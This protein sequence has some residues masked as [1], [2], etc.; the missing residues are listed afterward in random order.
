[1][2]A[3]LEADVRSAVRRSG[4]VL[5]LD[6][7]GSYG[8][9]AQ[10]LHESRSSGE[11]PYD[12]LA[13]TGSHLELMLALD[14]RAAGLEKPP[15][16]VHLP[17][18]NEETIK[19]TPLYEL[20]AAGARYRK[21]LETLV[22]E[23]A[24]GR[25]PPEQ[26]AAFVAQGP[27]TL[28][29]A[30][31]WLEAVSGG[32]AT[33][34]QSQLDGMSVPALVDDLVAGGAIARQLVGSQPI[35]VVWDHMR[36]R[37]GLSRVWRE[38]G[39][40]TATDLGFAAASWALCVEYVHDL[41]RRD[42]VDEHLA[43]MKGLPGPV[44]EACCALAAHLR[45]RNPRFYERTAD[46]TETW[47]AK[48]VAA[49]DARDLGRID[50]FR[51]EED[52]VLAAAL[53]ALTET[54]SWSELEL[55]CRPRLQGES[56]WLRTDAARR[57]AWLLISDAAR[58]GAA[59]SRA[60]TLP[61]ATMEEAVEHYVTAGAAVD[62]THRQLEQ[63]RTALLY[64]QLPEYAR[65]RAGLDHLRRAWRFWAD[66]LS[67]EFSRL[68][69]QVGFLPIDTLQQRTL[70]DQVVRPFTQEPGPTAFFVVDALRYEMGME[71][72]SALR[73]TPATTVQL[74]ARLAELPTVT[75]V[76]MNVLAPVSRAGKLSP[77]LP[78]N[79]FEG[80]HTGQYRVSDPDTR[81]RAMQERV[82][83]STC[84]WLR[85]SEVLERD[86]TSLK[87]AIAQAKLVVI[88]SEE[89]DQAGE[90]GVGPAV[91]DTVMQKLRAAWQLLREA[92][93]RRFVIT[94]DHGFL[95][96]DD[97]TVERQAHGRKID[98]K[99]R[100]VMRPDG[101]DRDGE[102]RVA[103]SELDYEGAVG[104]LVFADTTAV[105]DTG[106]RSMSFV[107]GGNSLQERVIPVLTVVHRSSA[108]SDGLQYVV[109]AQP[110]E[111]VAGMHCLE[112]RVESA[113][114]AGLSFGGV[115]EVELGL[116]ALDGVDIQVELCQT[117]RGARLGAG[118]V[119]AEVGSTF[120]LFFRLLGPTDERVR[121][122]V[123]AAA[124]GSVAAAIA[125]G[126]FA[127]T[128]GPG[129][130]SS[131]PPPA[132]SRD[133]LDGFSDPGVRQVF[134]HLIA[135]GS[136][137]EAEAATMLGGQRQLRRFANQFEQL[138]DQAPFRVRIDMVSGVKRYVREGL[139]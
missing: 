81:R 120:E 67:R 117:R 2:S 82:G 119:F 121:V 42:P 106:N 6:G 38:A 65:L 47:I 73:D 97:A 74:R 115:R 132:T 101:V 24:A 27:L 107:H 114:Q 124:G 41:K 1:M 100:H 33:G 61:R 17:G 75:E 63:R 9:F 118:T 85:L 71:L 57:S 31:A 83:G 88:H 113:S 54:E 49:A 16:L 102:V 69:R 108:G 93:V 46:D 5:W 109:H 136:V 48:E 36:A 64:P 51:F 104:H 55:W 39:A 128:P 40:S 21:S 62:L 103:L 8:G 130:P 66:G 129:A 23:A 127:V 110:R 89:I 10:T 78:G 96:L 137:T 45:E 94:A 11:L 135:H 59:L 79:R 15:L 92:G 29:R 76:G 112:L 86:P 122:E 77:I 91:F 22:T 12:V 134:E 95:L 84:P 3:A 68:C 99:R 18:F 139:E 138:A 7:D 131:A 13:W 14:T 28:D 4:I 25:V 72:A 60:G 43:G 20:Y 52:K 19:Q 70:F 50:T 123:H 98:P 111:D 26:I 35:E 58:L 90:K 34:L 37:L 44:R 32:V 53:H 126:R 133:W 87:R 56:F 116:R 30:D 80:F 125:E 105:F